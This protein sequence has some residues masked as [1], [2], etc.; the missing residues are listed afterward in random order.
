MEIV[1]IIC[2]SACLAVC[3]YVVRYDTPP[4]ILELDMWRVA[5]LLNGA[6][7]VLGLI[8]Y[9]LPKAPERKRK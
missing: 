2:C 4:T 6:A 1:R 8:L 5:G 7:A 9:M 3:I